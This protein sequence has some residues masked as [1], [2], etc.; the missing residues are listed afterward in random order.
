MSSE[1]PD[2]SFLALPA[3]LRTKIDRAFDL[4]VS[5]SSSSGL[6]RTKAK[7]RAAPAGGFALPEGEEPSPGGFLL[8]ETPGGFLHDDA[9][10]GFIPEA[11]PSAGGFLPDDAASGFIV[12]DEDV[13]A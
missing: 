6:S 8:D 1:H 13:E 11:G 7:Q 10:G 4:A 5:G 3:S 9:S 12:E 2:V